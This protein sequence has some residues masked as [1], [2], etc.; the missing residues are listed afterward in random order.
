MSKT[1]LLLVEDDLSISNMLKEYL[2]TNGFDVIAAYDGEAGLSLFESERPDLVL[3]DVQLPKILGTKVCRIIRRTSSVPIIMATALGED[4]DKIVGL[5][6]GADDYLTKPF[7]PRELLARVRNLLK[8]CYGNEAPVLPEPGARLVLNA[9]ARM[10]KLDGTIVKF[11][12]TE[13]K[14]VEAIIVNSTRTLSRTHLA[15]LVLGGAYAGCERAIDTHVGRIRKKLAELDDKT[16]FLETVRG[17]GFKI[18][19]D[20]VAKND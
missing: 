6:T 18:N 12:P 16:E 11:S 7:H 1:K 9:G 4:I 17:F 13:F 20:G 19:V 15:N 5:E 2:E 3:L 14:I 8:R 10:V